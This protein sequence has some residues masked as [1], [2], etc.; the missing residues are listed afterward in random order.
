MATVPV[1]ETKKWWASKTLYGVV[2]AA[3]A[4][5]L[6]WLGKPDL[7]EGVQAETAT[8]GQIV[9]Q[10]AV[11]VGLA[12]AAWGRISASAKLTK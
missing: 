11:V 2:I 1:P 9:E 4:L 7:A 10:I 12:L 5:F 6:G 8:V 3:V